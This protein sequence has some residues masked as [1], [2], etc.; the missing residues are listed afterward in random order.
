MEVIEI[1]SYTEIEKIKIGEKFL[2]PKQMKQH[3]LEN[4]DAEIS[5]PGLRSIVQNY[6]R[7]AGVRNLER[8]LKTVCRK[9]AKEMVSL[10]KK[11]KKI[12]VTPENI[13][14]FLGAPKFLELPT[15]DVNGTGIATGMAWTE[16]GGDVLI[17]EVTMMKGKGGLLLTGKLGDVMKESAQAALSYMRSKAKSLGIAE[18]VFAKNDIHVHVPEGAIP[19]DGPSAGITMATA[20]ISAFT[21]RPIKSALA[22]TGEITLR[23][24]VLPI[25]GLKE[26]TLAALRN[27]IKEVIVPHYN[28]KD[29]DDLPAYVKTGLKFHFVKT[30]DEVIKIALE[31]N[32]KNVKG[33]RYKVKVKKTKKKKR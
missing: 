30:M 5:E 18:E 16:F 1:N 31:G 8:E 26:K 10:G 19:K 20:L 24:R 13:Q 23:G 15:K 7:E 21:G 33:K 6:T 28:K 2:L 12:T 25:G 4:K 32:S 22:M 17:I 11:F 29:Y 3:G 9:I 27:G 14:K